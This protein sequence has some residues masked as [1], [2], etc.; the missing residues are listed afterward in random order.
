MNEGVKTLTI[1][2]MSQMVYE[3]G[4]TGLGDT[5]NTSVVNLRQ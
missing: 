2:Y 3:T 5:I 1:I 4:T